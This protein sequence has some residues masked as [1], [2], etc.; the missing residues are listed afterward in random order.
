FTPRAVRAFEP[1]MRSRSAELVD[2]VIDRRSCDFVT[3]FAIRYPTDI[4][5]AILG[6]P[7]EEGK[8]MVL[9][10]EDVFSGAFTGNRA[11]ASVTEIKAYYDRTLDERQARPRD[12]DSDFLTYLLQAEIDGTPLSRPEMLTVCMTLM[13]AGLHTTRGALGYSVHHLAR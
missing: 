2:E 12:P 10:V 11:E 5:L 8:Q 6:Q 7:V 1:L 4:L 3:E 13:V 9:W